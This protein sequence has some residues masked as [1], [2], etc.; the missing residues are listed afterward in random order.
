[1]TAQD[2]V[3]N[4][5]PSFDR[6]GTY[7]LGHR[8]VRR[9]GYGAMQ[10]AGPHVFGPPK[11]RAAAIAVLR[12]AVEAGV[13]HIDTSDYYGPFVVNELIREALHP[14]PVGL[15]I[16][17]K[18]GGRR[19]DKGA[20]LPHFSREA[21]IGAVHDNL[22]RLGLDALDVVNMRNIAGM[23]WPEE[24][25]LDAQLETLAELRQQGLI[26]HIGLSHV[27]AKQIADARRIVPFVCV[28][29]HYNLAQRRDDAMIDALEKDGIAYVPYFPL[30]GFSTLQSETLSAV[31]SRL[32]HSPLQVAL[33]WL[34][35]HAPNILLIPGTSSLAHLKENLAVAAITLPADA[36]AE[37]DRIGAPAT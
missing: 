25:S 36:V 29:N 35:Q 33:A 2:Q 10:L 5:M 23:P 7:R 13:D 8:T 4:P 12:A 16:V 24:V 1:M 14:Y 18:V 15:T 21:L 6:S 27:T 32:G 26:K 3:L 20:W 22:K 31:A 34:L 11:D 9:V 30:G 17:T 37:L 19:D 28:Q